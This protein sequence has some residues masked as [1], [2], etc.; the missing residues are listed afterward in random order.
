M[1]ISNFV[2]L[3]KT[4]KNVF[5][6]VYYANV[7]VT[8]GFFFKKTETR[9]IAKDFV[10]WYFVDSGEFTPMFDVETLA[11][12]YEAKNGKMK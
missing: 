3:E 5:D 9:K 8:T 1:K 7:D 11:R 10:N 12:A 2:Y 6:A 4:G